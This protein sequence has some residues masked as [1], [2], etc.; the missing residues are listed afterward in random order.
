M[1]T[2]RVKNLELMSAYPAPD[3]AKPMLAQFEE[4]ARKRRATRHFLPQPVEHELI[5]RLLRT[6]QWAPS[7]YNLQPTRFIVVADPTTRSRI[8]SACMNQASIEE[9]PIVI[10]F[11]GDHLASDRLEE[12]LNRDLAAGAIT[13]DYAK[14]L[15][16]IVRLMFKH[17]PLG[18]NWLWKATLIPL[19]RL[20]VPIPEIMAVHKRFWLA[21]QV[22]LCA[23]NFMLAAEAAGLGAVPM[24]GFDAGRLR[25]ALD[26]PRSWEPIL[27][28]PIGYAKT[29]PP[30][31]TRV[32]LQ[33]VIL[34]R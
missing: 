23:M 9:A 24:E 29:D 3:D 27:V 1:T 2:I 32:P 31:R 34:W 11:A 17:G 7:G 16:K 26:L 6:A 12:V 33:R 28:V 13:P 21:K 15:R 30:K 8:R 10:V 18:I 20:L 5:E 22:A 25:R 14:F 19:A 4:L